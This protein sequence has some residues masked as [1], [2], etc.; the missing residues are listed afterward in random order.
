[1]KRIGLGLL[2]LAL[3]VAVPAGWA[4]SLWERRDP[5]T[6]HLF[7]DTRARNLGDLLT[8]VVNESTEVAGADKRSLDKETSTAAA[9]NVNAQY[10][11][12]TTLI[13]SLTGQTGVQNTSQRKFDGLANTTIDRKLVDR[14]TVVVVDVLPNGY[15]V[16][17]GRRTRLISQEARTLVVCGIVRPIDI[18]S[19]NTVQSQFIADFTV[20]YEGKGPESTSTEQGWLGKVM[21]KIWPY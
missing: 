21:N 18:G 10:G 20:T 14:M 11:L 12:G 9:L 6:A 17:E 8:I 16:V 13:R 3:L 2:F 19:G 5:N 7:A 4:Q 1:M 15:L